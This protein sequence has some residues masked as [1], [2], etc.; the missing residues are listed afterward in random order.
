MAM[1]SLCPIID[2]ISVGYPVTCFPPDIIGSPNKLWIYISCTRR[3]CSD[4]TTESARAWL[5]NRVYYKV[6]PYDIL[7]LSAVRRFGLIATLYMELLF[8]PQFNHTHHWQIS[9]IMFDM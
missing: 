5:R 3:I 2:F 6:L 4:K 7:L 9:H 8:D 1:H